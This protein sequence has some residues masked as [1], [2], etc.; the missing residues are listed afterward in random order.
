LRLLR[1]DVVQ[2]VDPDA[3]AEF[4]GADYDVRDALEAER[5]I[6]T[7]RR[8][9]SLTQYARLSLQKQ[10][11]GFP[12]TMALTRLGA[13]GAE[14]RARARAALEGVW[15]GLQ[16]AD[17]VIDWEDDFERGGAWAL[18][19]A[20]GLGAEVSAEALLGPCRDRLFESMALAQ[21]L[22]LSQASFESARD[23]AKSVGADELARW[24][25]QQHERVAELEE[26]ERRAPGYALRKHRLR[27]FARE[28]ER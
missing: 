6:L 23:A 9:V 27:H 2:R 15:L 14:R 13:I 17:D 19:V 24:A 22:S 4:E 10:A 7:T 8:A 3:P 28:V 1:N 12:A 20:G 11:P 26:G 18:S 16:F 21:M 5:E 25:A